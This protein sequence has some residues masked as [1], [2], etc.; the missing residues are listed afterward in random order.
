MERLTATLV[1]ARDRSLEEI[2]SAVTNALSEH[3]KGT[4]FA[5]DRT[6][7]LLRRT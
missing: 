7:V 6:L 1:A 5:D 3:A 4:P 2:E